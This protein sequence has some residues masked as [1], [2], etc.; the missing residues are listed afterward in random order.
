MGFTRNST[1][2]KLKINPR[3]VYKYWTMPLDEYERLLSGSRKPS[4]MDE[5]QQIILKWIKENQDMSAAQVQDWLKEHYSADFKERTVSRYVKQLRKRHNLRK[6]SSPRSYEAVEELPMG[7]QVQVDFGQTWLENASEIGKT[8]VYAAVFLLSRSRFKYVC[9]QSRPFLAEDLVNHIHG[10]F[11]FF[12]GKPKEMV[13]DQD[14]IVCVSENNG[15]IIYTHAFEQFKQA[16]K[17]KIFMC[18]GADPE[19]KGKVENAVKFVKGNFLKNRKFVD[20]STLNQQCLAWLER[21]GNGK[22]HWTTKK[23]PAEVF[24]EEK[25]HLTAYTNTNP[26]EKSKQPEKEMRVVRKDNTIMFKSNRFSVP[27]GTYS[28]EKEVKVEEK[29]DVLWIST[30]VGE[31]ICQ[32]MIPSGKGEL[33]QNRDHKRDRTTSNDTMQANLD[34]QLEGKST[35]FLKEISL[36]FPRHRKDQFMI[37]YELLKEYSVYNIN[38]SIDYCYKTKLFS[39]NYVRDHL[40]HSIPEITENTSKSE[41]TSIPVDDPKY[42]VATQKRSLQEYNIPTTG[43]PHDEIEKRGEKN[44]Q[45]G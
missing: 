6:V 17:M 43:I 10:C 29:E 4:K 30:T 37:I 35:D 20:D 42:H 22:V 23:V 45:S 27:L 7:Q 5:Y 16:E 1:A 25:L 36:A 15:D 21:T 12:G 19:T 28:K 31:E 38:K 11:T 39:C 24:L 2:K 34:K 8:Q 3:T 18:R 9:C 44:G 32:H 41:E 13:F 14:S 26:N 33:V 40:L